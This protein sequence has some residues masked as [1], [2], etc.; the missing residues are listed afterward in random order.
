MDNKQAL[1]SAAMLETLWSSRKKDMIDLITPFI[2]YAVAK[3]TSPGERINTKAVLLYVREHYA[4]PDLPE[5]IVKSALAR[6]P[7]NAIIK[8]DGHYY[9]VKPVDETISQIDARQKECDN[10]ISKIGS[11][12]TKYLHTHCKK[13]KNM[14]E[15][16]AIMHLHSFFSKY[17]LEIETDELAKECI[18]PEIYEIDYYISRY[19]FDCKDNNKAQYDSLIELLEGYFLR[20]A[21]YI[22]P[23]NGNIKTASFSGTTFVIDAPVILDILGYQDSESME[24]IRSV[25]QI[26]N[27]KK[28]K[29]VYFPHIANE[30]IDILTAYKYSLIG[31]DSKTSSRT[32]EGLNEKGYT[33]SDVEREILL[34]RDRLRTQYHVVEDELP[35][36]VTK[37]DGSV[38][39]RYVL[40]EAEAKQFVKQNTKHYKEDNLNNDVISALAVHKLREGQINKSI[41]LSKAVFVT[42]NTDFIHAFNNYYRKTYTHSSFQPVLSVNALSAILWIKS[43]AIAPLSETELLR[44]AYSAM[45]PIPEIRSKLYHTLNK[46]RDEGILEPYQVVAIRASRVFQNEMWVNSFG[47]PDA[48]NETSV[49]EATAKFKQSLIKD[50]IQRHQVEMDSITEQGDKTVKKLQSDLEMQKIDYS[51]KIDQM[52]IDYQRR[53][54]QR[55]SD[56]KKKENDRSEEIRKKADMVARQER[57]KWLSRNTRLLHFALMAICILAVSGLLVSITFSGPFAINVVLVVFI[58]VSAIS[59]F[60]TILGQKKWIMRILE[61]KANQYETKVRERKMEE[62]RSF[63]PNAE[64]VLSNNTKDIA[65]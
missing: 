10:T 46:L 18:T 64:I 60:D 3:H 13:V 49:I 26:L 61:K 25:I 40:D 30:V 54:A 59:V 8:Q 2:L 53:L 24:S 14:T 48:I 42:Y 57:E 7:L 55:D 12:L 44:N 36:Y 56:E 52:K 11:E 15:E 1:I 22:Q 47:D 35:S 19:I 21:M 51:Q 27:Q 50:E 62:Y 58:L 38:D 45:Q 37:K 17:G 41:E 63:L 29:L 23:E 28:A 43:G 9:L 65:V 5:S 20:L 4:Y 16:K 6:K 34:F 39:E 32:L 33:A 31:C